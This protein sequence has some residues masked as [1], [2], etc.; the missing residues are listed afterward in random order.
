MGIERV[1][2]WEG[3]LKGHG[4]K[5]IREE[6]TSSQEFRFGD[7]QT[8]KSLGAVLLPLCIRKEWLLILRV[9][10]LPGGVPLLWPNPVMEELDTDIK[11]KGTKYHSNLFEVDFTVEKMPSGHA[12]LELAEYP[13]KIRWSPDMVADYETKHF[14]AFRQYEEVNTMTL[15]DKKD[16]NETREQT[17]K[18]YQE[19]FEDNEDD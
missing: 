6:A 1:P 17:K 16:A 18:A 3:F 2:D 11:T 13:E 14:Q 8:C 5:L 19:D 7:S 4:L 12:R 9:Q 10:L 15:E